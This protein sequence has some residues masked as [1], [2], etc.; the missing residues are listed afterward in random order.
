MDV[1]WVT[2]FAKDMYEVS[3]KPLIDSFVATK[4]EGTLV[5]AYE[6]MPGGAWLPPGVVGHRLDE[7]EHL[8]AWLKR[9]ADIIPK[10][11]GGRHDGRCRCP[12]GPYAVHAKNRHA[13]PCVGYWFCRNASR[14][15][16]KLPALRAAVGHV[17]RALGGTRDPAVIWLDADCVFQAK[18]TA[19]VAQTWFPGDAGVFY[20]RH[21]RAVL[22][23]GVVGYR[24][25]RGGFDVLG[26]LWDRYFADAD[27]AFRHDPRWDD[28]YQ[29]Q[30]AM[31][32][33]PDVAAADL[34]TGSGA[35][36]AVIEF[37]PL[38]GY[39]GHDKGRHGRKLNIMK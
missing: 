10:W 32:A 12:G 2:S 15:V 23:A 34:A 25:A 24:A 8:K 37:G 20:H 9:H 19:Q 21:K 6:R 28:C 30:Q 5:V 38:K 4:T 1:V 13:L 31:A 11:L 18:V 35:H 7:D 22:E 36:A 16:R 27:P 26:K 33:A 39:I 17:N 29:L 14:W 3:G